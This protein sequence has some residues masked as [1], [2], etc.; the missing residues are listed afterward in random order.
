MPEAPVL[1]QGHEHT[2]AGLAFVLIDGV[3]DVGIQ[4]L[5]F[6][7]PLQQARVPFLDAVSGWSACTLLCISPSLP[8][9]CNA[10]DAPAMLCCR[11][12]AEWAAGPRRAW[13]GL[14]Q[15]HCSP[16][17]T[18]IQPSQVCFTLNSSWQLC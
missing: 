5:G 16:V 4:Q 11:C 6:K 9:P 7:T 2:K 14:R 8:Y 3:G 1:Q 17:H 13:P 10:T 15:R 12:R 18:R